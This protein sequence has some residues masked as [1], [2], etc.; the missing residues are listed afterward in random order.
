MRWAYRTLK[1]KRARTSEKCIIESMSNRRRHRK[2]LDFEFKTWP[3]LCRTTIDRC[4][5]WNFDER[6]ITVDVHPYNYGPNRKHV[7]SWRTLSRRAKIWP[8]FTWYFDYTHSKTLVD[9]IYMKEACDVTIKVEEKKDYTLR[10]LVLIPFSF[11]YINFG[12]ELCPTFSTL[13]L[14]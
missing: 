12:P 5:R 13:E 8:I 10:E 4:D 14:E 1:P 6:F 3:F 7:E 9:H 2:F 11:L